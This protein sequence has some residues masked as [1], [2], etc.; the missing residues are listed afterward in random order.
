MTTWIEQLYIRTKEL[1]D[2]CVALEAS[3]DDEAFLQ[4]I[5]RLQ[6]ALVRRQDVIDLYEK[7]KDL[8]PDEWTERVVTLDARVHQ[9]MERL[10]QIATGKL[11]EVR[12]QQRTST[13][14]RMAV[15]ETGAFFD[16]RN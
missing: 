12:M 9:K 15:G 14:Y 8:P 1:D 11:R 5:D 6:D 10:F 3:Q 13:G 4:G 16:Q 7:L 2:L